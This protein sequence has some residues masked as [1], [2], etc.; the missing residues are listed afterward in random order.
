[1]RYSGTARL[2]LKT[3]N[4]VKRLKPE[5][6]AIIDH[7][8]LDRVSAEALLGTKVKVV[9]NAS[10]FSTGRYPN[11]GPFLL[12]S[13]GVYMIDGV[14]SNIFRLLKEGQRVEIR[15][16]EIFVEDE[17][18]ACGDVLTLA[19]VKRQM[20]ESKKR[21]GVELEKFANNTLSYL[22]KEKE[23]LFGE[24]EMPEIA[25]KISGRQVL[26]VVRGYDYK[27]DLRAL[28]SY[29]R[30]VKPVLIG[31]DGGADALLA[32]GLKPDMIIGDM[33]SVSD[34]SLMSGAELIVHAYA[35]GRCPGLYRLEKLGLKPKIFKSPGTSE[36]IA[37]LLAYEEGADL[38][39]A[40][41][42]HTNLVE[43]LDKGRE[44]MASTFLARLRVGHRLVDAKGVNKLYRSQVKVSHLIFLILATLTALSAVLMGSPTIRN[45]LTLSWMRLKLLLF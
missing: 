18:I 24:V 16:G 37:L 30:E 15:D 14:G 5:D 9:I 19:T 29:I 12:A 4:L 22:K 32:E 34:K 11:V 39:A 43:F 7:P 20:D 28:R 8:D 23:F 25:T 1:M 45:V 40:V 13:S 42:G 21:L 2:D 41:G 33:D 44:G 35:D 31:V 36:D 27:E 38:I 10:R 6:V 26:V 3:K 17:P